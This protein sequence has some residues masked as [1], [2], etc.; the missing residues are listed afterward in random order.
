MDNWIKCYCTGRDSCRWRRAG[1]ADRAD[2]H[3]EKTPLWRRPDFQAPYR[4]LTGMGLTMVTT[5][6]P[7]AIPP[8]RDM[9]KDILPGMVIPKNPQVK[10]TSQK[11]PAYIAVRLDISCDGAEGRQRWTPSVR[12]QT[13]ALTPENGQR[14]VSQRMGRQWS[15]CII[16]QSKLAAKPVMSL[17]R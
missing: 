5:C 14:W 15:M 9:A 10:N 8:C 7:A 13:S 6:N 12:L 2:S 17:N 1:L 4:R 16:P 3:K 11:E